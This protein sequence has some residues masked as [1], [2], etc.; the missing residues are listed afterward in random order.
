[1]WDHTVLPATRHRWHSHLYPSRS[2][3]SIRQP[4]WDARLSW[5]SWLV[6]YRDG[7]PARRRSPIQVLTGPD[8]C[9]TNSANHYA[10]PP[11]MVVVMYNCQFAECIGCLCYLI[12][13]R[14]RC[15][16]YSI[17]T[18]YQFIIQIFLCSCFYIY[19]GYCPY[20]IVT[21]V[22]IASCTVFYLNDM[23]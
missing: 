23:F 7:I 8:E 3:Y 12:L 16:V 15:I 22:E 21:N 5:P 1:M 19:S 10:T 6:T 14:F 20:F 11:T 18:Y 9:A 17:V 13:A 4:R 2:W